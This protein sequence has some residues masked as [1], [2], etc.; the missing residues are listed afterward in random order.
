MSVFK[1]SLISF[2]VL[3][4]RISPIWGFS[5]FNFIKLQ[6]HVH[7]KELKYKKIETI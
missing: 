2:W 6:S 5:S 7:I 4:D 1:W 3:I